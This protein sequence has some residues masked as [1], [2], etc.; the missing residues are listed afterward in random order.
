MA[1]AG[2]L[3]PQWP[4]HQPPPPL[5]RAGGWKIGYARHR[6]LTHKHCRRPRPLGAWES[7]RVCGDCM[8]WG[9]F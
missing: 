9:M 2:T 5:T 6:I 3:P 4:R 1:L 7:P 8:R